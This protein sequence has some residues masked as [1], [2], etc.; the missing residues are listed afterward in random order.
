MKA[1]LFMLVTACV[2]PQ[3][4][5]Y[6]P[7]VVSLV[8]SDS[9]K[10]IQIVVDDRMREHEPRAVS[11]SAVAGALLGSGMFLDDDARVLAEPIA[12][13]LATMQPEESIRI[14]A[15]AADAPRFYFLL[16]RGG[17]LQIIYYA[18]ATHSD[19]Y[20]A[21]LATDAV[22][23]AAPV[24]KPPNTQPDPVPVNDGS[25]A[26]PP[27]QPAAATSVAKTTPRPKRQRTSSNMQPISETEARRRIRELD[28]ALA[29][30][31]IT[32]PEL[33]VRRKEILAR[34]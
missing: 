33:K 28:E 32:Q 15:W 1:L 25:Q 23:I 2:N 22:A 6:H 21:A 24:D 12:R 31:L 29:A 7:D 30:G 3:P 13:H 26:T 18:G 11:T 16:I 19:S 14:V 5:V 10:A 9:D 17:R 8:D 4:R 34:L 27:A 20:S